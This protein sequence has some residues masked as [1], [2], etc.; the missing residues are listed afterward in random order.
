MGEAVGVAPGARPLLGHVPAYRRDRLAFLAS[1]ADC[2]E[3]VVRCRLGHTLLVIK[4]PQDIRYI[5]VGNHGNYARARRLTGAPPAWSPPYNLVT[6][7]TDE[8]RRRRRA[9]TPV[10]RGPLVG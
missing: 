1:C 3:P 5:L 8:N 6:A 4:D 7:P 9:L 10:L 2:T